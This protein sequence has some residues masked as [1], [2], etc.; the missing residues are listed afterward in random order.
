MNNKKQLNPF[1]SGLSTF[2][3]YLVNRMV[4]P[5]SFEKDSLIRW[6]AVILS[7]LLIACLAFGLFAFIAAAMLIVKEN[8]WALA[9]VD[10]LGLIICIIFLF[11]HKIRFEIRSSITLLVFFLIGVA[12]ILNV[13]PLS[14]GPAWLFAFAV[15]AGVLM[16][17]LA[18]FSAILMN[19]IFIST[20]GI[21][22]LTGKYGNEF[23]FFNTPQAM[24]AAGVNFIV[25]NAITAVSVSA[26]VKGLFHIFKKKEE[27][28]H[29]L[30]K[31][32]SELIETKQSLELEIQ[33]RK[34]TQKAL[35]ESE[36]LFKLITEHTSALVSIHD[37]NA[38]YLFASPSHERLGYRSEDLIGQSG[39]TMLE[40]EGV[41]ALLDHLD[42]AKKG[43]LSTAL[44]DYRL[45]DK[46]GQIHNFRGSF[47][48]V[49]KPDGSLERIVCVGEDQ[50]EL[51][52]AQEEKI[53]ALA[54]A[55]EAKKMAIIGQVAGKMAH[56]FNNILGIIMGIS[57]LILMDCVDDNI[58][59]NL[60]LILTQTLRGKNLTKNLV[61]FARSHEPKHEF[62]NINKTV[63]LV[64]TLMKKDMEHIKINVDCTP[65]LPDL[66]ADPGMIEHTLVNILQNAVHA[67]ARQ[68]TPIIKIKTYTL[69]QN[70]CIDVEDN[71]CGIPQKHIE[72]IFEPSF[73]LKG[74]K[75]SIG[76]YERDVKGTGYGLANVKKYIEQHNGKVSVKSAVNKGTAFSIA[77]P[78]TKTE[79]S[80]KEKTAIEKEITHIKK[81]ILLVEDE[82]AISNVQYKILT[83]DP[84]NHQVDI[85][86][87]GQDAIDLFSKNTYD[88]VSLDYVLPGSINGMDVYNHIRTKNEEIPILF[89]SGN[90]EFL[91]SIKELMQKDTHIDHL[92]KPCQNTKYIRNINSLLSKSF[93]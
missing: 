56:D 26:L 79:L 93:P 25:L 28:A 59:K 64:L 21:L 69:D 2:Q 83:Q 53:K 84:C 76:A 11:V 6:R 42:K 3:R 74:S 10:V 68:E 70:I 40:E 12:V 57:E 55:S 14:G 9:V 39:F 82:Q 45:K 15:L 44:L 52:K 47:D 65:D 58:K 67:T 78:V 38:D 54:V 51:R 61:A 87:N 46:N 13:G 73:T 31:E 33:D 89:I 18:A 36:E 34:Q 8:A 72:N 48:A 24:V 17:N 32:R 62:F 30:E 92:S 29:G 63:D 80:R 5:Y 91:E 22:I 60:E 71:G 27:L 41:G 23:P 86:N 77:L 7:S 19:A 43:E 85:A 81:Y 4:Y 20:I 49:F 88:F 37:S 35:Q 75:D 90:I 66:L 16:G 1:I 50:T